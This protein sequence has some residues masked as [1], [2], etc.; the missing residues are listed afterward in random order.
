M[1]EMHVEQLQSGWTAL[2]DER[3]KKGEQ[4]PQLVWALRGDGS[5]ELTLPTESGQRNSGNDRFPELQAQSIRPK[6]E[7]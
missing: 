7:L 5:E 2:R 6:Q 4:R 3:V 1:C